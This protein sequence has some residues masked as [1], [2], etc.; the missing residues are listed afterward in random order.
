MFHKTPLCCQV[1]T[2]FIYFNQNTVKS[3]LTYKKEK[4]NQY[5]N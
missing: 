1:P 3:K 4:Q 2:K 5:S